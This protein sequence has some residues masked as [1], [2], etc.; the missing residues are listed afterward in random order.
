ML[1]VN[2]G[3]TM[4]QMGEA[5]AGQNAPESNCPLAEKFW[6]VSEMKMLTPN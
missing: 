4:I 6:Q 3:I 5:L 2:S 1:E